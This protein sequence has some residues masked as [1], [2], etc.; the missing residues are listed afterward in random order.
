M[1]A[2]VERLGLQT[3]VQLTGALPRMKMLRYIQEATVLAAPS[4]VGHDGDRDGLPTTILEA[5]A[6]G[7]PCVSTDVTGI[8]EVLYDGN[9]GLMVSQHDSVA[10]ADALERLL[11]DPRLGTSLAEKARALIESKFDIHK[12]TAELREIFFNSALEVAS[13]S[14]A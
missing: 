3:N 1:R 7:T 2:Q 11:Q 10:L 6:L 13:W 8:P 9:T 4:V 14:D 5:M 12:N